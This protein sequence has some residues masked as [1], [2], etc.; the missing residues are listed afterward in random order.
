MKTIRIL[1]V[2]FLSITFMA[3]FYTKAAQLTTKEPTSVPSQLL[4]VWTT[5]DREVALNMTFMY[6]LNAKKQNWWDHVRL[7]I[8]GPSAK[9]LAED[10]QIQNE[11]K[12]MKEAGVEIFACKACADRY[13]V[14]AKLE[15]LGATVKYIG[16]DLT[17]ML[18][19]G[20]VC[21]TF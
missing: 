1:T 10:K 18:K 6:T 7:I 3:S 20:W 8:W 2:T 21:L 9:V 16:Q 14:S 19:K 11:I 13:H 17:E 4:I 12:K 15:N 5:A